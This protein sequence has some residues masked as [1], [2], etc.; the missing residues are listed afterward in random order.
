MPCN[1]PECQQRVFERSSSSDRRFC[2]LEW[3]TLHRSHFEPPI[4]GKGL[5][6]I[7]GLAV[8]ACACEGTA[9]QVQQLLAASADAQQKLQHHA[10]DT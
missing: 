2:V 1:S 6:V 10:L 7:S 9:Q 5:H 4:V 3:Q 8:A